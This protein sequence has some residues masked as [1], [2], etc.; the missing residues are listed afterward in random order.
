MSLL[1]RTALLLL[2]GVIA[3]AVFCVLFGV[4]AL[5]DLKSAAAKSTNGVPHA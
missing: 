3:S 1:I 2:L 4:A 5:I